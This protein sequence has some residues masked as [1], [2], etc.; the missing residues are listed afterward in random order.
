[1]RL[2]QSSGSSDWL[3]PLLV[4]SKGLVSVGNCVPFPYVNA[5]L[6]SGVA[7]LELIQVSALRT[8]DL[9]DSPILCLE[10]RQRQRR[11][12]IP[13]G[14]CGRYHAVVARRSGPSFLSARYAVPKTLRRVHEVRAM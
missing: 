5:A 10:G 4:V 12:E 2:F 9:I 14:V 13:G 11:S 3:S 6:S 7:L 1:M 8:V